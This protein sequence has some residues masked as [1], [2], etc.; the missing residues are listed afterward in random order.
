M[1]E[2]FCTTLDELIYTTAI[3]I[4]TDKFEIIPDSE[5]QQMGAT[6]LMANKFIEYK[7]TFRYTIQT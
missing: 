7:L 6:A 1:N 2:T 5:L 4:P 3:S